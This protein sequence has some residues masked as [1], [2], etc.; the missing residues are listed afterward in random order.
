MPPRRG[1][2]MSEVQ[3]V[4]SLLAGENRLASSWSSGAW[5]WLRVRCGRNAGGPGS[6]NGGRVYSRV[7]F[8]QHLHFFGIVLLRHKVPLLGV[9]ASMA[10][11][12]LHSSGRLQHTWLD[13]SFLKGTGM[14]LAILLSF[15]TK[16][17]VNL[18]QNVGAAVLRMMGGARSLLHLASRSSQASDGD[19]ARLHWVLSVVF[20]QSAD[21][22]V[23]HSEKAGSAPVDTEHFT[24]HGLPWRS[25]P[26]S[27]TDR[28]REECFVRGSKVAT[29]MA[30]PPRPMMQYVREVCDDIFD[31]GRFAGDMGGK[32]TSETDKIRRW[33]RN[34]DHLV[35]G[36]IH[37][38]DEIVM[39]QECI[40]TQ[41]LRQLINGILFFYLALYPWCVHDESSWVLASTCLGLS[42]IFYGLDTV[43]QELE[44]S[45]GGGRS[46]IDLDVRSTFENFFASLQEE[47]LVRCRARRFFQQRANVD[48]RSLNRLHNDF[49]EKADLDIAH[50]YPTMSM[51]IHEARG[52]A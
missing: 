30:C 51:G 10:L 1:R 48:G 46:P 9:V 23:L 35:N 2:T 7:V 4:R 22:L 5:R 52:G 50:R 34:I 26:N 45:V 24:E 38:F 31:Y 25:P 27:V 33:H 18:R 36:I 44:T 32:K 14:L 12:V 15:R 28:D 43:A 42:C 37:S 49:V 39:L 11:R 3:Q 29:N 21:W 16:N 41:Q 8:V 20:L 17:A 19:W 47:D 13:E 6:C 40:G